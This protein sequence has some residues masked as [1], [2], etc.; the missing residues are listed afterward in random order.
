MRQIA[1]WIDDVLRHPA[2]APL[3]ERIRGEVEDLC[4][5]FPIYP[6]LTATFLPE[7]AQRA[8]A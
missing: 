3:R 8:G 7:L 5:R 6:G 2:D 1:A 4:L